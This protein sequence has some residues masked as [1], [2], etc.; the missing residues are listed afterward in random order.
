[1]NFTEIKKQFPIFVHHPELVYLDSAA[2]TQKP[3]VVIERISR[4]YKEENA[5]VRRGIYRLAEEATAAY[6]AARTKIAVFIGAKDASEIVFTRGTTESVNIV[7][8]GLDFAPEDE[9]VITEMEHHSNLVP[10]QMK[11][12]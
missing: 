2:T 12:K 8:H 10:W 5:N 11:V 4:Y 7:A 6:E 1:M 3:R 9:I